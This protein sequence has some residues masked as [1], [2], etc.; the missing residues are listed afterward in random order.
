M[1]GPLEPRAA[2]PGNELLRTNS[3]RLSGKGSARS[4][5]SEAFF[6]N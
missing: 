2:D 3:R 1:S 4:N 5:Q 6:D